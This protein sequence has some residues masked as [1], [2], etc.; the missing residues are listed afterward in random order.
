MTGMNPVINA[1]SAKGHFHAVRF[2]D[3]DKSLCRLVAGFLG[4][5]LAIG[6]AALVVAT[7]EHRRGIIDELYARH[8]DVVRMHAAGDLVLVDARSLMSGFM[9]DNAPD[10]PRFMD[11]ANR[12][13][14]R[15]HRR[16]REVPIRAYGEMV[17]LL[18]KDGLDTAAIQIE[19]LWN[20]LARM[21]ELSLLCGYSMG[22]F[23][24]DA[25]VTSICEE[26]THVV[27]ADGTPVIA[28]AGSLTLR[29]VPDGRRRRR[30]LSAAR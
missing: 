2:Y 19:M 7:S 8:F 17:D 5:G 26:H 28:D 16:R 30:V 15:I 9:V 13:F 27:A 24:K 4:E 14:E 6:H 10:T 25:C 22:H 20:R 29:D 23:Y 11:S 12:L 18:W 3:T 1:A 21:R